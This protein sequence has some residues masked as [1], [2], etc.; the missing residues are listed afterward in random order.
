[1]NYKE[2]IHIALN[3]QHCK[4]FLQQIA[5]VFHA[6]PDTNRTSWIFHIANNIPTSFFSRIFLMKFCD[7][8]SLCTIGITYFC[9]AAFYL[10]CRNSHFWR[11]IWFALCAE[12]LLMNFKFS[13]RNTST[14]FSPTTICV[15]TFTFQCDLIKN[16]VLFYL[17]KDPSCTLYFICV[18]LCYL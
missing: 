13:W 18:L 12:S 14:H 2:V 16:C 5:F 4:H 9:F 10:A 3:A 7:W 8:I 17:G 1:M 15:T 6:S 11:K